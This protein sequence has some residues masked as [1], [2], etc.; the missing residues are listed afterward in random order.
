MNG[1]VLL[2]KY[3]SRGWGWV[4][5]RTAPKAPGLT[6]RAC[7]ERAWG[8]GAGVE[9][10]DRYLVHLYADRTALGARWYLTIL[11][12]WGVH[13]YSTFRRFALVVKIQ[14]KMVPSAGLA[15]WLGWAG[16]AGLKVHYITIYL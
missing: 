1:A 12:P 15:G 3:E 11:P 8:G 5:H 10:R 9:N 6:S 4:A 16:L 2:L 13:G 14:N 7:G